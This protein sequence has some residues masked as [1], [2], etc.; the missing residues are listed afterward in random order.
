[1]GPHQECLHE[2]PTRYRKV[3]LTSWNRIKSACRYTH[4]LPAWW[5]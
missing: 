2:I 1:M 3:V 5:Y 4:P